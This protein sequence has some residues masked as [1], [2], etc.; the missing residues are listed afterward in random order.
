MALKICT[1][2]NTEVEDGLEICPECGFPF[3][4][5]APVECPS[6]RNMVVFTSDLC[7]TCG[8]PHDRLAVGTTSEVAETAAGT[9]EPNALA[10]EAPS[11]E[12]PADEALSDETQT[13][14]VP[15]AEMVAVTGAVEGAES[16]GQSS[17]NDQAA[18]LRAMSGGRSRH[19]LS[20]NDF[21]IKAIVDHITTVR[22]DLVNNPIKDFLQILTELDNSNKEFQQTVLQQG[23]D[24]LT[25]VEEKSQDA[26]AEISRIATEQGQET[27]NKIKELAVTLVSEMAIL[28]EAQSAAAELQKLPAAPAA[29][30][31]QSE[32]APGESGSDNY[33]EYTV[34]LCAAMLLFTILNFFITIYAVKLL[35]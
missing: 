18:S 32:S 14:E 3:E 26:L 1:E 23:Q 35:R 10:S 30:A 8:V 29:P 19:E 5:L 22:A 25:K 6:C 2:C 9:G 24:I 4:S 12:P 27:S 17:P 20:D 31:P 11:A 15:E 28:K 16:F 7:P 13:D 34:Y 33:S 21:I